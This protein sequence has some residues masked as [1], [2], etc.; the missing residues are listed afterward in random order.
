VSSY[1]TITPL[2]LGEFT[3]FPLKHFLEGAP[4]DEIVTAPCLGW[5]ARGTGGEM[6]VVDTG[7]GDPGGPAGALHYPFTRSPEQRIDKALISAG[8]DPAE[9][10][11][12]VFSHLHFDHCADGEFLP[13]AR[14]FVQAEELR[15]AVVPG[16]HGRAYDCGHAG[17]LP[18][19][20]RV[21]DRIEVLDGDVELMPGVNVIHTPGHSPGSTSVS[22]NTRRGR[23][24]VAG[25]MV[26]RVENWMGDHDRRHINPG[27]YTDRD[28]CERSL[29]RLET[30]AD[31]VL[32]SHDHRMLEHDSYPPAA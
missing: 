27:L 7:M 32:A 18:A 23:Y 20:L 31:V 17:V 5:L 10:S 8:V 24:A 14:F 1:Y 28:Q 6:V 25:D 13:N 12:V 19:W 9:I 22:F 16:G 21:F 11:A 4:D 30:F 29:A 3:A 15:Y 2:L 26:N